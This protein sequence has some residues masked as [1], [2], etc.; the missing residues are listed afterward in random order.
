MKKKQII[1]FAV[2]F[3]CCVAALAAVWKKDASRPKA[4]PPAAAAEVDKGIAGDNVE[5]LLKH[6]ADEEGKGELLKAQE[7]LKN[8]LNSFAS[9]PRIA[10]VQKRLEG[11]NM[12]ILFSAL[13]VPDATTVHVVKEGDVLGMIAEEHRTTVEFIKKQNGLRSDVIRPG[14]RLRI[15]TQPFSVLVDKS[16]NILMLKSNGEVLKTYRVST[17]AN[18]I[19]PVGTF[20]IINRLTNPSWTHDGKLIPYG[21]P[22]NILGTRW[23]GFDV[24][25]YGIHGTTQPESIGQQATAGCVRMLN[26]D[27]EELYDLLP[28]RTEVVI[29]D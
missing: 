28:V 12:R 27:V 5:A 11:L 25:S 21:D 29:I 19:T 10:E 6:A 16:Q 13:L 14:M 3:V 17:G 23:M 24:P 18:N 4:N 9:S 7:A 1:V 2:V 20:K 26:Q 15:W 8:I 22:Q